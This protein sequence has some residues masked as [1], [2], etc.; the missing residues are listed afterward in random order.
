MDSDR[1]KTQQGFLSPLR[2]C[3]YLPCWKHID[4]DITGQLTDLTEIRED[5]GFKGHV[6]KRQ[7]PREWHC[8]QQLSR[9]IHC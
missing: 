2:G 1:D 7:R 4:D 6:W 9:Q 3:I 8:V 5:G